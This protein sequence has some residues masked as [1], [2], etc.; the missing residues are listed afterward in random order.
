MS[1]EEEVR[2]LTIL[3]GGAF[4]P[5]A[6]SFA[7]LEVGCVVVYSFAGRG[8]VRGKFFKFYQGEGRGPGVRSGGEGRECLQVALAPTLTV[9]GPSLSMGRAT[10]S[11]FV[12]LFWGSAQ[13]ALPMS[14]S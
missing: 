8:S 3:A 6:L 14:A 10:H 13:F 9:L 11:C 1:S 2:P 5:A 12:L 7:L 4:R